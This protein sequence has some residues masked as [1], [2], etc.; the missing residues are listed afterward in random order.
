MNIYMFKSEAKGELRAFAGDAAGSKLPDQFRPWHATGVVSAGKALPHRISRATVEDA[1][2]ANGFQLW[3]FKAED[4][5]K[6]AQA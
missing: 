4:S 6:E 3:R 2:E 5:N 1:I